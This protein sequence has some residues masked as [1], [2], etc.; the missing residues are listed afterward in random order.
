MGYL[1]DI[2]TSTE[3]KEY[4]DTIS[5]DNELSIKDEDDQNS[6]EDSEFSDDDDEVQTGGSVSNYI[7]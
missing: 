7:I 2:A 4:F 5:N 1:N 6:E 3:V